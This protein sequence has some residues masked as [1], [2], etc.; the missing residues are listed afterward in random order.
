MRLVKFTQ[1]VKNS[2]VEGEYPI[3][4]NPD[5]VSRVRPLTLKDRETAS[6]KA[7]TYIVMGSNSINL[8]EGLEEV[9]VALTSPL[10]SARLAAKL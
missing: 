6:S 1:V 8:S 4:I 9:V 5:T 2:G 3:Y 7:V 10:L